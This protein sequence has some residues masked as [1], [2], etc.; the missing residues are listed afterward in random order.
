MCQTSFRMRRL[1]GWSG[2]VVGG[3]LAFFVAAAM[4]AEPA[5]AQTGSVQ[6]A[7]A[8]QQVSLPTRAILDAPISIQDQPFD[9]AL[10]WARAG[11]KH[12]HNHIHDYTCTLVK[13][14]RVDG[15]LSE[16]Q[17]VYCK[18]R[19]TNDAGQASLGIYMRFLAPSAVQGRE[20]LFVEGENDGHMIARKGGRRFAYITVEVDPTSELA[21]RDNRY[22]I[23]EFG[24]KNLVSRLIEVAEE[25][26]A[27]NECSVRY[28]RNA[29]VDGRICTGIEVTK[30][31]QREDSRFYQAKIYIDNELQVPIHFET[32]DW[33][34]EEGGEPQLLEQYTYRNLQVNLGMTDADFDRNNASYQL[35]KPSKSD[36]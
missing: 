8:I 23:T 20:V 9:H 26:A 34:A 21:M 2:G 11:L 10:R 17:Y 4:A 18:V 16:Y 25:E 30:Q 19:H 35:R 32:Y 13:R 31:V 5:R 22:P 7:S 3:T 14:E 24:V 1:N 27:L 33:P 12:I 28:F 15:E 6:P 29:K 36:R